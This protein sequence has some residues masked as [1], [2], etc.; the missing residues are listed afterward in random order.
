MGTVDMEKDATLDM[1]RKFAIL[2]IVI[3]LILTRDTQENAGGFKSI[4]DV[5]LHH[6]ANLSIQNLKILRK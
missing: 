2:T 3:F 5:N 1:R 4:G 6:F